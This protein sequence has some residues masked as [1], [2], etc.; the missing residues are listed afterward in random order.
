MTEDLSEAEREAHN[1]ALDMAI[2]DVI[3]ISDGRPY[4]TRIL[5]NFVVSR[6][7]CLKR[8]SKETK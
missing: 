5:L 6:L 2:C 4:S 1:A 7:Q 3:A 8:L